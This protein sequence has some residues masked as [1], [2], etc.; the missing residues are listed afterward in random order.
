MKKEFF[1]RLLTFLTYGKREIK[2]LTKGNI[3][4]SEASKCPQI[5][6]TKFIKKAL[7]ANINFAYI[8]KI[9]N[10]NINLIQRGYIVLT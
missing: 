2:Q 9:L 1:F 4:R 8:N 6:W 10:N 5:L 7:S 3:F